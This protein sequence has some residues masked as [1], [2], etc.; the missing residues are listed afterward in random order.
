MISV[1]AK[2]HWRVKW[3]YYLWIC[4]VSGRFLF[5]LRESESWVLRT[6]DTCRLRVVHAARKSSDFFLEMQSI[7]NFR[8]D[9]CT[10]Q[11]AQRVEVQFDVEALL[12]TCHPLGWVGREAKSVQRCLCVCPS[13]CQWTSD[14]ISHLWTGHPHM[15]GPHPKSH[16]HVDLCPHPQ[17]HPGPHL[18]PHPHRCYDHSR[19]H[20]KSL[21]RSV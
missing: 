11:S 1:T 16:C 10:A 6:C 5:L 14:W 20:P 9:D 19:S 18:R 12:I 21:L 7:S 15:A 3:I 17:H 13:V 4:W 2:H 8:V